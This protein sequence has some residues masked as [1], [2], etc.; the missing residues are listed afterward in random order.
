MNKDNPAVERAPLLL[1]FLL[2]GLTSLGP[3]SIDTYLPSF[4]AIGASLGADMIAVQQTL[5]AYL[6]PFT[7]MTLWHG[8]LSDALGRKRV[9][10][11]F[12]G[13]FAAASFAAATASRIEYLWLARVCQG[14]TAGAG[15]IIGRAIIRDL[16][17]GA[18]AQRL[19]A[20]VTMLFALAPAVAPIIGGWLQAAFGWRAVFVFLGALATLIWLATALRLPETLPPEKR[21]SLH[22]VYLWRAYS[23]VLSNRRFLA[24]T[25]GIGFN[26]AGFFIY[27][28][29][30][31]VFLMRHLGVSETGFAWLFVPSVSGMMLG[32]WL[33]GRLAGQWSP[34]RTTQ[35]GFAVMALAA[36]AN[37]A[38]NL[39]LPPGLP[40]SVVPLFFYTLGNALAMPNLTLM[41]LDLYP[42][43]RG[44]AASCQSFLQAGLSTFGAGILA[45]L[46]WGSTLTMAAGQCGLLALGI[47][48][49]LGPLRRA[50]AVASSPS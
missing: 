45:P 37:L 21:Q 43:Q 27:V 22:P 2:A 20:H 18:A 42:A 49:A 34:R 31:P 46:L 7:I 23:A 40:W 35:Y 9:I 47:L 3:F 39:A 50:T 8:A 33:S 10:L 11:L 15:M 25:F 17:A 41:G 38:L 19:M 5:T 1:V 30:A 28:L 4:H 24:L 6:L 14:T 32:A 12:L 29:A 36:A 13:L 26:F 44:M 48:A 16:H